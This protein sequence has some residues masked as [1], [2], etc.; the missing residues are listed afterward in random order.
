MRAPAPA[1]CA[2]STAPRART[3]SGAAFFARCQT[4]VSDGHA[5]R[6]LAAE[7]TID[8]N[9]AKHDNPRTDCLAPF[10]RTPLS[11]LGVR[12]FLEHFAKHVSTVNLR[13]RGA[14]KRPRGRRPTPNN[15]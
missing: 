4:S 13:F 10:R 9:A 5:A 15:T 6:A 2:T 12:P 14:D 3:T 8:K 7:S 1:D 11:N